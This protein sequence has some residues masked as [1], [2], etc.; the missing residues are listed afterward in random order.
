MH[1]CR[2]SAQQRCNKDYK[3]SKKKDVFTSYHLGTSVHSLYLLIWEPR[4]LTPVFSIIKIKAGVT[5][6]SGGHDR[7]TDQ[8]RKLV[9]IRAQMK[10]LQL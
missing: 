2:Q 4:N 9:W 8:M 5:I 7:A 10:V 6:V 1:L 3:I